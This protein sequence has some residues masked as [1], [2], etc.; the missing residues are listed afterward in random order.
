LAGV[1]LRNL[2]E[3]RESFEASYRLIMFRHTHPTGELIFKRFN[4]KLGPIF[5]CQRSTKLASL[6]FIPEASKYF[7]N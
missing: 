5:D 6:L 7:I 3:Q 1:F 4:L 2:D